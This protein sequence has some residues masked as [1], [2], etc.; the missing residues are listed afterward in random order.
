MNRDTVET[1]RKKCLYGLIGYPLGHSFSQTYFTEKFRK[2]GIEAVY[3]NFEIPEIGDLPEIVRQNPGL[4]GFNITIPYKQAV[5]PYLRELSEAARIIGA[6]N[7]VCIRREKGQ[8]VL[9]GYNTDA[10]GFRLSLADFI[11][12]GI[13]GALVLGNGGAARAVRYA[14][15]QLGIRFL[16]VSR[17]PRQA[18]EIGYAE[19]PAYLPTHRLIVN[20]TPLGTW[21]ATGNCPDLPYGAL[22]PQH[23][24]FDLV[25][26]PEITL[27]MQ[28]GQEAGAH[29][30]NGFDMLTGQAEA[31]WRIWQD[32]K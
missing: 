1:I 17:T 22:G 10:E 29:V 23:Y 2:E 3:R 13:S 12:P 6:V 25:Y 28:K 26:N 18:G 27:F 20:T 19:V 9:T 7:C 21:P 14:L 11:P 31:A 8:P 16:T 4:Q 30:R 24:L 32:E 5:L 15:G